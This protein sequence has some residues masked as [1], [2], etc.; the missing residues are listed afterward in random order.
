MDFCNYSFLITDNVYIFNFEKYKI[1]MLLPFFKKGMI[2]VGCDE[3]GRGSL[4]GPVVAAAVRLPRDFNDASLNDSKKL[5][6]RKRNILKEKILDCAI[7]YGIGVIDNNEIDKLNILNASIEAMHLAIDQ[8]EQDMFDLLLIDGNRFKPYKSIKH[9]CIVKGDG[10]YMSIAAAS[11]LAKTFRDELM[12][13]HADKYPQ[14]KWDKNAGYP[15]LAHR[16]AI[17]MYG[18]TEFHRKSFKLLNDQLKLFISKE[19]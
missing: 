18:I 14:Y 3:A 2:E 1:K 8:L 5:T 19:G 6:R 11:V 4:A 9:I 15:T 10:R 17:R 16:D 13:G 7:D 12:A